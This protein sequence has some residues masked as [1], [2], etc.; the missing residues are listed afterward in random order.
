MKDIVIIGSGIGGISFGAILAKNGYNVTIIEKHFI[1]GG[2]ATNFVRKSKSGDSFLFDVSLHGIGNLSQNRYLFEELKN[3]GVFE[4]CRPLRKTENATLV[5]KDG[6]YF[7]IPDKFEEYKNILKKRFPN[8]NENIE[9]LFSFLKDFDKDMEDN[10][11]RKNIPPKYFSKLQNISLY[12]FLKEYT[13]NEKLIDT[14]S[15]LW[16]YYGLPAKKLNALYYL[17]AWISY[18]IGGTYYLEGGGGAF[19]KA[20]SDI[21]EENGGKI[22]LKEEVIKLNTQNNKITSVETNKGTI[23]KGDTFIINGCPENI[24]NKI[25]NKQLINTYIKNLKNKE[26][27]ISL[28]QLYIGTDINPANIGIK[29]ADLFFDNEESSDL[30]Y[31]HIKNKNYEKTHFGIVNYN[32]LDNNLNKNTG[33]LAVTIG[34]FIENWPERSTNEYK[35]RKEEIKEIL[36]NRVIKL[37]PD[38][39][40]HIVITELATPRT[41]ERYT[42][43]INGAVYGFAQNLENGGFNRTSFKTPLSNTFLCSAWTQPGGGYEGALSSALILSKMLMKKE[44]NIQKK[45]EN[46]EFIKPDTFMLGMVNQAN[47]EKTKNINVNYKFIFDDID[48][49]YYISINHS[50]IKL[51]KNIQNIDVEI[52]CSYKTWFKI[53]N[54]IIEGEDAFREGKLKINGDMAKFMYIPEIFST[55][56]NNQINIEKKLFKGDLYIP[57]ALIPFISYWVGSNFYNGILWLLFGT[58]FPLAIMPILK[59]EIARFEMPLLER[60]TAISFVL[61]YSL[62]N[63]APKFAIYFELLLPIACVLSC[64]KKESL[65]FEYSKWR[66]PNNIVETNLFRKINIHITLI[67]AIIFFVQFIFAKVIFANNYIGNL[68]YFLNIIGVLFSFIYPKKFI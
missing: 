33:F 48:K 7:D 49:Q 63:Y 14:F 29:K 23:I 62:L 67:W 55:K 25:D 47:L 10:V 37:F 40:N 58:I 51:E 38:L 60:I 18:H 44:Q 12:D 16:L 26:K 61:Y 19:S 64:F 20:F 11:L 34:D 50:K 17:L 45:E 24:F 22:I 2:Y 8:E 59:P 3:T 68:A 39:K 6:S 9:K 13:N 31:E 54:N 53:S 32:L 66:Y 41:M 43:N 21:I 27:C 57:L 4:K 65:T 30:G 15:F 36:L 52:F 28:T 46:I 35:K 42:N 1:V 5:L 56:K